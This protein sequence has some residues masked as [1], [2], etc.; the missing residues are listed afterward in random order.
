[1]SLFKLRVGIIGGSLS[2]LF[3]AVALKS[4]ANHRFDIH[5]FEKSNLK[6]RGA[7]IMITPPMMDYFNTFNIFNNKNNKF[8]IN[9]IAFI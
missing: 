6:R 8:N 7:G 4:I 9:N 1:M 5:V 2:G 3:T